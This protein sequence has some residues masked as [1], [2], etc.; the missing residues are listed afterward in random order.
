MRKEGM[1]VSGKE[2]KLVVS[3]HMSSQDSS[4]KAKARKKATEK[5][6]KPVIITPAKSEKELRNAKG[7]PRTGEKLRVAAYCRVSTPSENQ[8]QSI[9]NQKAHFDDYV[10]KHEDWELVGIYA[11]EGISGTS[12]KKRKSFNAMIDACHRGE[13]DMILIK[14]VARYARNIVDSLSVAR[15]LRSLNP[16]VGIYF[17]TLDLNTLR[18]D[19]ETLLS[20]MTTCTQLEST[21]KSESMKWS[22]RHRFE[23]GR[24]PC[25]TFYLLGYDT[26]ED[27]RMIINEEEAKTVRVIFFAYCL[28]FSVE[29]IAE[30]LTKAHRRTGWKGKDAEGNIVYNTHWSKQAV[31]KI[32]GNERYCGDVRGQKT[33]TEDAL[34]HRKLRNHGEY[35]SYFQE[36]HHEGIVTHEVFETAQRILKS[37]P[38]RC[39]EKMG[40]INLAVVRKGLLKG[41]ILLNTFAASSNYREYRELCETVE[42]EEESIVSVEIQKIAGFYSLR[43]EFG[44]R[45]TP[46]QIT[47][48]GKRISP[49]SG[50][51][52]LMDGVE[53]FELLLHPAEH[54]LAVRGASRE[55]PNAVR[56]AEWRAGKFKRMNISTGSMSEAIYDL[57]N[58]ERD[59]KF[60]C[61]GY[62]RSRGGDT[63]ILFDLA[64]T[65]AYVPVYSYDGAA[66]RYRVTGWNEPIFPYHWKEN[67]YGE[68][69][70]ERI[71]KCRMHMV[72]YFGIWDIYAKAMP[73]K[74]KCRRNPVTMEEFKETLNALTPQE[75]FERVEV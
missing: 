3:G 12:R 40:S 10:S 8:V 44:R 51:L 21:Q 31:I 63:V 61:E 70:V 54:L 62:H 26:D 15:E 29:S 33:Y 39:R 71:T 14:D 35:P 72:D 37:E 74:R 58:W 46:V 17:E 5:S 34:T 55:N 24:F 38:F 23:N 60:T 18:P 50:L 53:Y 47:L 28:G 27:G 57:M 9:E 16:P 68:S 56:W 69:F 1:A 11:D 4:A 48:T 6:N 59:W 42:W 75:E 43:S 30:S 45:K 73:V 19:Y 13:I 32:L 67:I 22:Y 66:Q 49:G 25:P 2:Y 52:R 65:I 7:R 36:G 41:F 64:D 20:I